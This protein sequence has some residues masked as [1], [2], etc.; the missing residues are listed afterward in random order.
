MGARSSVLT[1]SAGEA[2]VLFRLQLLGLLA[3]F[4]PPNAYAADILVFSPAMQVGSM[5]SSQDADT[6]C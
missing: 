6:W 5:M 3:A 4:S 1:G 2:Y